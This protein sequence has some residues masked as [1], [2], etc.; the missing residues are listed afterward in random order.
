MAP[1]AA[2]VRFM[3]LTLGQKRD[4]LGNVP[5]RTSRSLPSCRPI[6]ASRQ[7]IGRH[8]IH[9]GRFIG[10]SGRWRKV[11]DFAILS[12]TG[13]PEPSGSEQR[14]ARLPSL[15]GVLNARLIRVPAELPGAATAPR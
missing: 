6:G 8:V 14:A 7:P 12:S 4:N 9:S 1:A 13:W 15:E 5:T 11:P 2:H 10:P 3:L